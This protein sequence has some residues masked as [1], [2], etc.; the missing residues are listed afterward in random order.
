M[1]IINITKLNLTDFPGVLQTFQIRWRKKSD[2]DVLGSYNF[3]PNMTV[4]GLGNV[5]APLP[6]NITVPQTS[7]II[8][9]V[10]IAGCGDGV[11]K[12]FLI[13]GYVVGTGEFLSACSEGYTLSPDGTYCYKIE[14]I[15]PTIQQSDVCVTRSQLAS[16]YSGDGTK[17]FAT[18]FPTDLIGGTFTLLTTA[19]WKEASGMVTGPMNR[20]AVW[21]DE[22]CDGIKDALVPG[23][24]LQ[25]SYQINSLA[26]EEIYIGI[27]GDNTFSVAING[28]LLAE[29]TSLAQPENFN[30]WHLIPATLP[31]G[32]SIITFKAI[33]DGSTNDAFAAAIYRNTEA[34][35]IA[36]TS[37]GA[38]DIDFRTDDLLTEHIDIA[39]CP[40][41]YVLDTTA[42]QGNYVC[43]RT[44]TEPP[45]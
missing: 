5:T 8:K 30:Y 24:A 12:E 32:P 19:Y 3:E 16:Q 39:T 15:A 38:L 13:C 6:Y 44:L 7:I 10:N 20:M 27:G 2:P 25:F 42:G 28:T 26:G 14:T 33:G 18:G 22:N 17:L 35:L 11:E 34:E 43:T 36:A 9:A 40:V 21:L 23:R 45:L 4:D 29:N 37:D 31:S 1:P 41:G